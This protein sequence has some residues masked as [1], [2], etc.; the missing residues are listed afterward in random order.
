M[1][2]RI[3]SPYQRLFEVRLLHHYWLDDGATVFDNIPDPAKQSARLLAY[4]V[5]PILAA[6]PTLATTNAIATFGGVFK[7]SGQGF[8]VAA[9]SSAVIPASTVLTFVVSIADGQL[10]D[11]TALTLRPQSIYELFD[12]TDTSPN[13]ITY[14]YKE[15]VPVLSNLTGTTRSVGPGATLFLSAGFPGP[16]PSDQVEALV[17]SGGALLQLTSDNP[18]AATQ[19]L[20]AS[21][22]NLPAYVSQAD[23]PVIVAPA[24]VS[25]APARG[26][27]LSADIPDD[28]FAL[29]SLTAVR[30]SDDRFSFV[31][32]AGAPK[33]PP[34]VY[35]VR[36]RN[37][38]TTWI[39]RDKQTG[40]V[41]STEPQPLPLTHFGNAGSRQKPS[42][43]VIKAEQTGAKVTR[44]IS[45]IYV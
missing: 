15:N 27:T 26:V 3:T 25:G 41:L 8:V 18:G 36:F 39:Y 1:A 38:S 34:P 14:R 5:R 4:D 35:H 44:L 10:F 23:A 11:Y 24:G 37:R 22:T 40:A 20:S 7:T 30:A 28:V 21:V 6:R 43:G 17:V 12:P 16:S 33:S 45:E 31:D 42:R 13:R 9:P 29:I 2:E 19:Q 32:G